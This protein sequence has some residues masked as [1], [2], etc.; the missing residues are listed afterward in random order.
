MSTEPKHGLLVVRRVNWYDDKNPL[1]APERR[2]SVQLSHEVI[3]SR[4]RGI[5]G[6]VWPMHVER[7]GI[8]LDSGLASIEQSQ[9]IKTYYEEVRQRFDES[10]IDL[11]YC[12]HPYSKGNAPKALRFCGFDY[13]FLNADTD[14]YS[15]LLNEVLYGL[16]EELRQFAGRLNDDLLLR[17]T[18][19]AGEIHAVRTALLARGLDLETSSEA[20]P[21]AIFDAKCVFDS[22]GV[23]MERFL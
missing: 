13:G 23:Q 11:L 22:D 10:I 18:T 20:Y 2:P 16:Y 21:L 19:D 15:V 8:R 17:S 14:V 5:D 12:L 4:Y 1:R 9:V 3:L 7:H 6:D